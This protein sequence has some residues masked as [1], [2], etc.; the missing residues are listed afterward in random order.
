[1][2]ENRDAMIGFLTLGLNGHL[3]PRGCG[4]V[5]HVHVRYELDFS[6]REAHHYDLSFS[7]EY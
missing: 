4:S 1:M 2:G 3:Y 6:L 7:L 5:V